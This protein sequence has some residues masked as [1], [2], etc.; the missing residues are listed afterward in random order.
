MS[1]AT[2]NAYLSTLAPKSL[3]RLW[4]EVLER[5]AG[6]DND[7]WDFPTLY[8]VRPGIYRALKSVEAEA[9]ARGFR[10]FHSDNTPVV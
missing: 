8:A 5:I 10:G 3:G 4:W 1:N 9:K 7:S 2:G 6:P